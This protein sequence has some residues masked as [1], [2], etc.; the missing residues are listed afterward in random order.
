M[1]TERPTG[2]DLCNWIMSLYSSDAVLSR[3][4]HR[5]CLDVDGTPTSSSRRSS[6]SGIFEGWGGSSGS[7]GEG[8]LVTPHQNPTQLAVQGPVGPVTGLL[9]TGYRTD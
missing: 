6:T 5:L 3:N 4:T 8:T 1:V 7:W 9:R 2:E